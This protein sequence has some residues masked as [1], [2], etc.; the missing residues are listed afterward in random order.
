VIKADI[1]H[2]I[3][4]CQ[5]L[6]SQPWVEWPLSLKIS[7]LLLASGLLFLMTNTVLFGDTANNI[8]HDSQTLQS[9]QSKLTQQQ[10]VIQQAAAMDNRSKTLLLSFTDVI[11]HIEMLTK[12]NA[13]RIISIKPPVKSASDATGSESLQLVLTGS[14]EM[15]M[16]VM[17]A[18]TQS[19]LNVNVKEFV[20]EKS[21]T[22]ASPTELQLMLGLSFYNAGNV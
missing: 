16:S 22:S 15:L 7:L 4:T 17:K 3:A 2:L 8:M 21:H 10:T 19:Q 6:R 11:S 5:K 12:Q 14:Y 20:L 18:I 1:R 13:V 9:L